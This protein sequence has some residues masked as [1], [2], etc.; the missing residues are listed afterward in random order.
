M[1][2]SFVTKKEEGGFVLSFRVT[3]P[4][5]DGK[6]RFNLRDSSGG[7]NTLKEE[8]HPRLHPAEMLRVILSANETSQMKAGDIL[9]VEVA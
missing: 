5:K 9:E 6:V 2:D 7:V 3:T 1:P 4:A 8:K